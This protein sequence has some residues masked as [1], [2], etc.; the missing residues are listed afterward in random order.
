MPLYHYRCEKC[1]TE[2]E[3]FRLVFDT[4]EVRCDRCGTVLK[5]MPSAVSVA[6]KRSKGSNPMASRGNCGGGGGG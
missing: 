5:K 2:V 1:D 3:L 6:T 4:D